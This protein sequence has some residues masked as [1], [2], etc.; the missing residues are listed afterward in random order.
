MNGDL[1]KSGPWSKLRGIGSL[2]LVLALLMN[3]IL[4][5]AAVAS[6]DAPTLHQMASGPM[7]H[8]AMDHS[9]MAP[10]AQSTIPD[11]SDHENPVHCMS[12]VC[13]FQEA[14]LPVASVASDA[15]LTNG[16]PCDYHSGLPSFPRE[17]KDRPPQQI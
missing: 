1:H 13:C 12:S 5:S 8:S 14:S 10:A 11:H 3:A 7:D 17:T 4:P 2:V 9:S 15:F 16:Q 6:Q